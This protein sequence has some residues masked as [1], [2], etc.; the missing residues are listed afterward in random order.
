MNKLK[1]DIVY[2]SWTGNTRKAAEIIRRELSSRG[3]INLLEIK[4]KK[5]YPYPVWLFLSFFPNV[6]VEIESP[7]LNADIIFLCLPKWTANC[8]PITTFLRQNNL[9][10]KTVYLVVT[11]GGFDEQRY[12]HYYKNKI[13]KLGAEVKGILL[14]KRDEIKK[15]EFGEIRNWVLKEF[16]NINPLPSGGEG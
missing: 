2:F 1:A 10:G 16:K 4:P 11:C 7:E 13:T 14:I 15:G 12:A 6:G 9:R 3:E 8:P 5:N